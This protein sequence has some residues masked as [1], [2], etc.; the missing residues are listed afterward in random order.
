MNKKRIGWVH[1]SVT[2]TVYASLDWVGLCRAVD[3]LLILCNLAGLQ[4]ER[5]WCGMP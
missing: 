2:T 5:M 1:S 4:E 3:I